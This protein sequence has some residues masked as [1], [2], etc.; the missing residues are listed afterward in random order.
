VVAGL[1]GCGGSENGVEASRE[2]SSPEADPGSD[3][4]TP[5]ADTPAAEGRSPRIV[6]LGTSLTAGFGL[7]DPDDAYPAVVQD[8]IEA[9]GYA[10]AVDNAGVSGATSAGGLSQ[11]PSLLND[12]LAVLIVELGANDGLRGQD[13]DA[14]RANLRGVVEQTRAAFPEATIVLGGMEAPPN[15][16]PDYAADFRA[17]F[18]SLADELDLALIPFLLADVAGER[19]RNQDDGIHPNAEGHQVV[20]GHVW[21]VLEPLLASRC[22]RDGACPEP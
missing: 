6:F 19:A 10:Y 12:S 13:T 3:S 4:G 11:L 1:A 15:L 7:A 5:P 8:S 18:A 22:A 17:V 2:A 16:G 9:A 20:A 14:L 21:S